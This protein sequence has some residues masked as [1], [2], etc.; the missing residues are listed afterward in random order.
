M[1]VVVC[2]A[3]PPLPGHTPLTREPHPRRFATRTWRNTT[4]R[5]EHHSTTRRARPSGS[6]RCSRPADRSSQQTT[7]RELVQE[8]GLWAAAVASG[9]GARPL[10][11]LDAKG[12]TLLVLGAEGSGVRPL[13]ARACDFHVE[14]PMAGAGVGSLNVSVAAGIAL[15]ECARQRRAT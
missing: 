2:R 13:V 1:A 12:P 9:P 5:V 10:A 3:L 4:L 11:E 8:A 15:Y 7:A 14:I 6:A